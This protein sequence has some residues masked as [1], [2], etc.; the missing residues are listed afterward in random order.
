M[1]FEEIRRVVGDTPY[2]GVDE[3][4][5]LYKHV[6]EA[7]PEHCLE[8]GHAHG[9]SSIYIAGALEANGMGLLDTVDLDT[10]ADR[11][12]NIETLLAGTGLEPRV[13]I[14][15]EKSSYTWFLKNKIEQQSEA[16]VCNPCYDFCFIDGPK[17]WTIDGL[18]FFLV[19]KL[20][21]PGGWI[22]FD[23]YAWSHAKHEGR[24]S[25][26]GISLR[27][28]SEQEISEP[29]IEKIFN[30]LVMQHAHYSNFTLQDGWW[31]WAQKTPGADRTLR[32]SHKAMDGTTGRL[33]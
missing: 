28:L 25:T 11:A 21:R 1:T 22:L 8:L 14:H 10:S 2:M 30:L 16:G 32:M 20:L 31:A 29:H 12:P 24:L 4:W 5:E 6:T 19:D 9:V 26:D 23:D 17:N 7:K 3:G 15:R 13:R 27:S 33:R 18:A